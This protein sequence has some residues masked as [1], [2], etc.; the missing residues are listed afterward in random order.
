MKFGGTTFYYL[1]A[2]MLL[3]GTTGS[4]A[5]PSSR[6]DLWQSGIQQAFDDE[7]LALRRQEAALLYSGATSLQV[8]SW[9]R[10]NSASLTL[11]QKR[12]Q[13][14]S[15]YPCFSP[16][17]FVTEVDV[18]E[19]MSQVQQNFLSGQAD[20]FNRFAQIHN[21]LVQGFDKIPTKV[22]AA[23]LEQTE[24]DLFLQQNADAIHAQT[25]RA[26]AAAAEV[27]AQPMELPGRSVVPSGPGQAQWQSYLALR[28][29]LSLEEAQIHNQYCSISLTAMEKALE[30]W[31]EQNLSRFQMLQGLAQNLPVNTPSTDN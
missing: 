10:Q 23:T 18:P 29:Q 7:Q 21:Q 16:L 2:V 6:L 1:T 31:R 15:L 19:G 9:L 8:T 26:M 3:G 11:Q 27:A 4:Q 14:L 25:I 30:Q 5:D 20:L 12:V 22:M 17:D 28:D 24:I 13:W